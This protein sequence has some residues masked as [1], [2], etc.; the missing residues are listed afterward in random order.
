MKIAVTSL[1]FKNVTGRAGES[2]RFMIVEVDAPCDVPAIVWL[3]LPMQMSFHVF[4][5]GRHPLDGMDVILTANASQGFVEELAERGVQVITSN[6]SDPRKAVCDFLAGTIK[7]A[8][9]HGYSIPRK[10]ELIGCDC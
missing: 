6:E 1:N 3:H 8:I 4:S 5:G 10:Q 9:S 2:R 7:P